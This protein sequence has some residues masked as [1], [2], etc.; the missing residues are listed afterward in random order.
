MKKSTF[1][2]I[3][4]NIS[5]DNLFSFIVDKK[6]NH[7]DLVFLAILIYFLYKLIVDK[8]KNY[9]KNYVNNYTEIK[10]NLEQLRLYFLY[11]G[12]TI[13]LFELIVTIT[14][15]RII[16]T[17]LVN[18]VIGICLIGI[19]FA[20]FKFP[21]LYKNLKYV[22]IPFFA[23]YGFYI[24]QRLVF[25]S[26]YSFASSELIIY[27]F[28]SYNLFKSVKHYWFFVLSII[29]LLIVLYTQGLTSK[30]ITVQTINYCFLAAILNFVRHW[31]DTATKDKF[32]FADSIINNGNSLVIAVNNVG[33]IVYCS[34]TVKDILGYEVNEV[35]GFGFWD[36]TKD[37]DFSKNFY[38]FNDELYIRTLICKNNELKQLQWKDSQ[39]SKDI[40]VAIGQDVTS[41]KKLEIHYKKLI[42]NASDLILETNSAGYITFVNQLTS[43]KLKYSKDYFLGKLF[44]DLIREDYKEKIYNYY[45]S[46][47][48][49]YDLDEEVEFPIMK[50]NNEVVWVSQKVSI[51]QDENNKIIQYLSYARDI[52]ELKII[53]LKKLELDKKQDVYNDTLKNLSKITLNQDFDLDQSIKLILKKAAFCFNLNSASYWNI[54]DGIIN[55]T[56]DHENLENEISQVNFL[57]KDIPIYFD[58]LENK[59][60]IIINDVQNN[61]FLDLNLRTTLLKNN[62]KSI[63]ATPVFSN[64]QLVGK[65][66]LTSKADNKYWDFEDIN[67]ANSLADQIALNIETCK[68]IKTEKE[69]KQKTDILS[70]IFNTTEQFVTKKSNEEIF[71]EILS[72][73]GKATNLDFVTFFENNTTNNNFQQKYKWSKQSNSMER[74][75]EKLQN[76]PYN[77]LSILT[78]FLQDSKSHYIIPSKF[79]DC[80]LKETLIEFDIKSILLLPIIIKKEIFGFITL[81]DLTTEKKWTDGEMS[82]LQTLANNISYA[83]ERNLNESLLEESEA[84]FTLLANNIPGTVYLS[85]IDKNFTKVYVN[86]EIEK[87]TGYSKEDFLENE[88]SYPSIIHPDDKEK[89]LKEQQISI[90]NNQQIHSTYRIIK[91]N[92]EIVWIEEFGESIKKGNKNEYIGGIIIDITTKKNAENAIFEKESAE[93][94][95]RA[96]SEFLANMSHEIRT[97][98]NGIIG[99][100]DLLMN[101]ALEKVQLQYMNT[102]SSSANSLMEVINNVLDFSKIEAGKLEIEIEKIDLVQLTNQI[103]DLIKFQSSKKGINLI[104]DIDDD[105]PKFIYS[106]SVR[107]KQIIINLLSNAV[108]FTSH[109]SVELKIFKI[110]IIN[111]DYS[112]LRISVKDTGIGIKKVNQNKIFQAFAQEDGSTTRKFGGTG[113]GLTISNKLLELLDSELKINSKFNVGS[114]FY[115]DIDVKTSVAKLKK[116]TN[117]HKSRITNENIVRKITKF[118]QENYKILIV[119]DNKINML[120]SKTLVKQIIPNVSVFEVYDGKQAVDNF[121]IINPDLI[122]MDIQMPIM[123]GYEATI[124][125]RK[126]NKQ[127]PII[128]LTAGIVMGEKQKCID[129]GM[130][131]Y[132]SKPIIKEE[133]QKIINKWI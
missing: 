92:K 101:T 76:V 33:E 43:N 39:F 63:L 102:I 100:T 94:A 91:K 105:T 85:K 52:T 119:E 32:Q 88:L 65:F 24:F 87:L 26:Q 74:P 56:Y 111:Q 82:I 78:N 128:A 81:N 113:L 53:E 7:L 67:F 125:L 9:N 38:K 59:T 122:F 86:N 133:L 61:Q 103:I 23:F 98:L 90:D 108:K 30:F 68:R 89:V 77:D 36:L 93:A 72:A 18:Y 80:S 2:L 47:N 46:L 118:S 109:G 123:N 54:G 37:P 44:T 6:F 107:L 84:R 22:V 15:T 62:V 60:Q 55:L 11:L 1:I 16:D 10:T 71:S 126:L 132:L 20:S 120:L 57:K 13:P 58:E 121:K 116:I 19:Y 50:S 49:K 66:C 28:I 14:C 45:A 124:E 99:F 104:L 79:E 117:E 34:K 106:D 27:I 73:L 42:E 96:K 5:I 3:L 127:I 97:P 114:E 40:I 41:V 51:I 129:A 130:N 75:N 17:R 70:V 112:T 64:G 69:L 29:V 115:F 21:Y 4:N 35:M 110:K 48:S 31:A 8:T 25:N 95:N 12:I 131:D 83:I